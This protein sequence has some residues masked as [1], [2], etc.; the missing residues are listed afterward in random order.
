M[1]KYYLIQLFIFIAFLGLGQNLPEDIAVNKIKYCKT[2]QCDN[3][4]TSEFECDSLSIFYKYDI[5]GQLVT[6]IQPSYMTYVKESYDS[7]VFEGYRIKTTEYDSSGNE[8][9][10]WSFFY[11]TENP[12]PNFHSLDFSALKT[13]TIDWNKHIFENNKVIQDLWG[14]RKYSHSKKYFY[15]S[16][17]TYYT[18]RK[19]TVDNELRIVRVDYLK[20]S[21]KEIETTYEFKVVG[22]PSRIKNKMD[23]VLTAEP[24]ILWTQFKSELSNSIKQEIAKHH[25]KLNFSKF[26]PFCE[27]SD[28][29]ENYQLIYLKDKDLKTHYRIIIRKGKLLSSQKLIYKKDLIKKRIHFSSYMERNYTKITSFEYIKN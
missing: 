7:T 14:H 15:T 29:D 22:Y 2:T 27:L 10:D 25:P 26:T 9:A 20:T 5:F 17:S 24:K 23:T 13:D 19:K 21:E 18:L 8:T 1:K 12:I 3:L 11:K 6:S 28:N 16:D 4:K